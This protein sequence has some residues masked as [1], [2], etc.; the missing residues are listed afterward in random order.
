[1]KYI[2]IEECL[3]QIE[4]SRINRDKFANVYVSATDNE[5][6]LQF[7]YSDEMHDEIVLKRVKTICPREL[8]NE[9][10]QEFL[11]VSMIIEHAFNVRRI[12]DDVR[13]VVNV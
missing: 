9:V 5:I 4:E 7:A 10:W 12:T 1:M 13:G 8:Q 6:T 3:V 2:N 11:A